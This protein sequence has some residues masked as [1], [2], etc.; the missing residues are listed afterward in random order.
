MTIH[1]KT[2]TFTLSLPEATKRDRVLDSSHKWIDTKPIRLEWS[3]S[4]ESVVSYFL[5]ATR[6]NYIRN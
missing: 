5:L 4:P 1:E 3:K 6:I 2:S